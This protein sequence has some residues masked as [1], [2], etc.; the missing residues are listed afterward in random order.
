MKTVQD[1]IK[2]IKSL[3]DEERIKATTPKA[4]NIWDSVSPNS[5]LLIG[6]RYL[7]NDRC[8]EVITPY[9]IGEEKDF[10]RDNFINPYISPSKVRKLKNN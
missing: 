3:P 9:N 4:V 2:A 10:I 1:A 7:Y 8:Y 6:Y 5:D